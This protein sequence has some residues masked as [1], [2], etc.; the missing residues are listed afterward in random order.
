[1]DKEVKTPHKFIDFEPA[2]DISSDSDS[3]SNDNDMPL[4]AFLTKGNAKHANKPLTFWFKCSQRHY[5][6][7]HNLYEEAPENEDVK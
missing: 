3:D 7:K 6:I 4:K 2:S 5:T 1:M